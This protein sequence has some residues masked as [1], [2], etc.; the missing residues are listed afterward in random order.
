[1]L[2]FS[3]H[4][5]KLHNNKTGEKNCGPDCNLDPNAL[6]AAKV[7]V[8]RINVA[9]ITIFYPAFKMKSGCLLLAKIKQ[10]PAKFGLCG[11][12][13]GRMVIHFPVSD[14]NI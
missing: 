12:C 13:L 9:G 14:V 4:F 7:G 10:K 5:L 6:C 8:I 3:N 11:L 2:Q 1:M